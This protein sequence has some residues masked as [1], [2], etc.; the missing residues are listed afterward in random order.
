MTNSDSLPLISAKELNPVPVF[1]CHVIL[2]VPDAD[3]KTTGRVANLDGI[4]ATGTTEREIL[5]S[6]MKQFREV[7]QRYTSE[8]KQIP[9]REKPDQPGEGE[10]ERFIPVHL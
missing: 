2:S 3:G 4:S 9:F 7:M 10:A 6:V 8:G 1:S 5:T